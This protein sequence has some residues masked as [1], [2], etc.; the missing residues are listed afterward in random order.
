MLFRSLCKGFTL[1]GEPVFKQAALKAADYY[2]RRHLDMT[3]PYWGGTLDAQCEDKEGAWAGFQA[4]LAAYELTHEARYLQWAGHAMDVMLTYTVSWDIDL[5]PGRL[6]D[7]GLKTRGWTVVSAQNQ[8]LD[9][10]AVVATPSIY[11]MG[12]YLHRDDLKRLAAVM[13]RSCGQMIDP[14][15]SQGEQIDHTNFAQHGDMSDVFRLRGTY[16]EGWTVFWITAHFLNA[17]AQFEEMGV[18]LDHL[19]SS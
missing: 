17:A 5:P 1:F 15:G 8:H 4:F 18:D 19:P 9:V 14:M 7:H 11:R 16:S 13:F 10:F 2:A 3:E 12:T 6:R